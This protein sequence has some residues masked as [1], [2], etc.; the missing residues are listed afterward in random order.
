MMTS[1][2]EASGGVGVD[3]ILDFVRDV[4]N[5]LHGLAEV[6]AAAFFIEDRFDKPG[7]WS[8]S[9]LKR[10]S[11]GVRETFVVAEVEVGFRSRRRERKLRHAG[12]GRHGPGI[13][14]EVGIEFF[15]GRL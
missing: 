3:A 10:V 7:R 13:D 9:L 2:L 1:A 11:F 6:I 15:G 5:D 8:E 12:A 4:G 14:V